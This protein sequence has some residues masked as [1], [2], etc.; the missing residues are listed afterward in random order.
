MAS[1]QQAMKT[2]GRE[3][4][5]PLSRET[6]QPSKWGGS[7]EQILLK[8]VGC[9]A[10]KTPAVGGVFFLDSVLLRKFDQATLVARVTL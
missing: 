8:R 5:K 6:Q 2:A 7:P 9:E 4:P 10:R 3:N 1:P